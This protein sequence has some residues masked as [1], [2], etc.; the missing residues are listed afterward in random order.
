MATANLKEDHPTVEQALARLESVLATERQR[1][2]RLVRII[3][4]WGSSGHPGKIKAAVL[5][6]LHVY[7]HQNRIKD[8]VPG[9]DYSDH[10]RSGQILLAAHPKLRDSLRTDRNNPGI[11]FVAL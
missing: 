11:T 10:S 1:G 7:R 5:Q 9:D 3:H 6:Q 4:G 2:V 8:F